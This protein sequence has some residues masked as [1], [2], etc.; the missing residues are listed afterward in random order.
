MVIKFI[1]NGQLI[2]RRARA[3][4]PALF[5]AKLRQA[6]YGD[7]N[8]HPREQCAVCEIYMHNAAIF[9]LAVAPTV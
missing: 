9:L 4:L 7:F 6:D 3:G 5:M 2:F 8:L 1:T